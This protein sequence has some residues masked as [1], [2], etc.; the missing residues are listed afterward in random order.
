MI[1]ELDDGREVR[2]DDNVDDDTA[3]MLK[4]LV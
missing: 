2:L 3:R 1:L 4:A